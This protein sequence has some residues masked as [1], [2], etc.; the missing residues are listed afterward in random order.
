MVQPSTAPILV[1]GYGLS[2]AP[3]INLKSLTLN[4]VLIPFSLFISCM[5]SG[6]RAIQISALIITI[7]SIYFLILN[8]KI[9]I[10]FIF[11]II[12]SVYILFNVFISFF[13]PDE[14]SNKIKIQH[15]L[16]YINQINNGTLNLFIGN[17]LGSEYFTIGYDRIITHTEI[18]YLDLLRW[19]G[20][21]GFILFVWTIFNPLI[22]KFSF[23]DK[24]SFIFLIFLCIA[25]SNPT[26]LNSYG[27]FVIV[28]YWYNVINKYV[29][30]SKSVN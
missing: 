23:I 9:R 29:F 6:Q 5:L 14:F 27:F 21:F 19:Y 16:S 20:L 8:K 2:I 3:K 28:W 12:L 4:K 13:D 15:F 7:Y 30:R 10:F 1:I 11:F 17:G 26:L 22:N 25:F 24:K 18:T